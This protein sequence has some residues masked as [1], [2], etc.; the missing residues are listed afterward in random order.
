MSAKDLVEER[1]GVSSLG[2]FK[3]P[4]FRR[5]R[6]YAL[7]GMSWCDQIGAW[8]RGQRE[9]AREKTSQ[10]TQPTPRLELK[11]TMKIRGFPY[12]QMPDYLIQTLLF[13]TS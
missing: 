3:A 2:K 9:I 10:F 7:V 12:L 1:A 8:T 13:F 11:E 4:D 6:S 5:H